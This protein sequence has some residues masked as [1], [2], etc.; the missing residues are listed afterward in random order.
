M[1]EIQQIEIL[2][3][4]S[5]VNNTTLNLFSVQLICAACTWNIWIKSLTAI[6][7]AVIII[8]YVIANLA[9]SNVNKIRL[10]R[11]LCTQESKGSKI[12]IYVWLIVFM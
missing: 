12:E 3:T 6:Y 5:I 9:V 4:C 8:F 10:R 2:F 7:S 1:C 11:G